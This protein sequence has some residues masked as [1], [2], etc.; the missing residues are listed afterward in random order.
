MAA[1]PGEQC[2][3][4]ASC[5]SEF[6]ATDGDTQTFRR[7]FFGQQVLALSGLFF[8]HFYNNA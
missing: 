5:A 7:L 4:K 6:K 8:Q 3:I 2:S 1:G